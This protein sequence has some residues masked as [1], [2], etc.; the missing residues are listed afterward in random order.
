MLVAN[1]EMQMRRSGPGLATVGDEFSPVDR[2]LTG[3]VPECDRV[4][5]PA[6][7]LS[8]H[9]FLQRRAEAVKMGIRC[10]IAVTVTEVDHLAVSGGT[11]PDAQDVAI[12]G[13]QDA[14][15]NPVS[16]TDVDAS[17]KVRAAEFTE[18]RG[19]D[20]RFV[21]RPT[22]VLEV[23]AGGLGL[24]SSLG[25]GWRAWRWGTAQE[26]GCSEP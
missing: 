2:N 7:L 13:C 18:G 19:E 8:A 9:A 14:G 22:V 24:G 12:A 6:Q 15:A 23:R 5:T 11:D 10:R 16:R 3:I 4:G 1:L 25:L 17:V 20:A 26:C 21:G